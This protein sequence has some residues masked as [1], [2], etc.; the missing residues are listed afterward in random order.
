[1]SE[2][3]NKE[4]EKEWGKLEYSEMKEGKYQLEFKEMY[5]Q[6]EEYEISEDSIL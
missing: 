3:I 2:K 1:M 6:D 4:L 5:A